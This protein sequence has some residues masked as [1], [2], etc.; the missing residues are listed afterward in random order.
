MIKPTT[1]DCWR[2]IRC[3]Q[4]KML[5]RWEKVM[6]DTKTFPEPASTS[7]SPSWFST[8][9]LVASR[10]ASTRLNIPDVVGLRTLKTPRVGKAALL[11]L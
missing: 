4:S 10:V 1:Q 8:A 9:A 11:A 5:K 2:G 6:A 7:H 3:K